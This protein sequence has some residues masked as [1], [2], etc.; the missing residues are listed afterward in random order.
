MLL[1]SADNARALCHEALMGMKLSDRDARICT[2][3]IVFATLRGLDSHGI[4]SIL[5]GICN[6]IA[7]GR[8]D[9]AAEVQTIKPML[10]KG[11][12]VAGPV[13]GELTMLK[14][15]EIAGQLG[16]GAVAAYNC[17]HFGAASYYAYLASLRGLIGIC[18]C[19]AGPSVA[20]FGGAKSLHGTNPIAYAAPGG[21]EPPIVL[22]IATS[23]AA[24]G[25]VFKAVRRGQSIPLGWAMDENGKPTTD[26]SAAMKGTLLPFG[27]HKGYGLGILVD[28]ITG[29]LAASTLGLSVRQQD[30]D[31]DHAGQSFFM[32][33]IDPAFYG[34]QTELRDRV[35]QLSND[36]HSIPPAEGFKEVLL[37]GELEWREQTKRIANGIPLYDEDWTALVQGLAKAGLPAEE[38]ANKYTPIAA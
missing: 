5:P 23:A 11:N 32:L 20:P 38:I 10:M 28:I 19:N 2:E 7:S 3:A 21:A 35:D 27:G 1:L 14:A 24:H 30:N 9:P 31:R 37:P 26:A 15:I 22:D 18:M 6:S 16:V 8:I 4:I 13:V 34:G 17:N 29:G 33:A 36:A 12:G 25:Q